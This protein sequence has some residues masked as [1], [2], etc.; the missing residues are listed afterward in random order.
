MFESSFT[1]SIGVLVRMGWAYWEP[2]ERAYK[3]LNPEVKD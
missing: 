3:I 2:N 1:M